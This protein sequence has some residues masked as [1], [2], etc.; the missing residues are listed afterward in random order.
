MGPFGEH[1]TSS[2]YKGNNVLNN[3]KGASAWFGMAEDKVIKFISSI[4][5]VNS[6]GDVDQEFK[7]E[8]TQ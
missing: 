7:Q 5:I 8:E 6:S 4:K 1:S 2:A 3:I